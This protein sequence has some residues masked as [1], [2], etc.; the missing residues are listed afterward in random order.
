LY[1]PSTAGGYYG[2]NVYGSTPNGNEQATTI[3]ADI[4]PFELRDV[5]PNEG[6]NTGYVTLELTGSRFRPNMEVW[7]R[8]G[9]D[10]IHADTLIYESYYRSFARFNLANRDTGAYDVGVSSYCEGESVLNDA[11]RIVAG[12]PE[13]LVTNLVFPNAPRPNRMA[14]LTLEFGNLGNVDI[15]NAVL[16]ITSAGGCP[17]S[18]T[19]EGL[20]AHSTTLQIPL[21][22]EGQPDGL[23]R[24]GSSGTVNIYTYTSGSLIFMTTRIR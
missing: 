20:S 22:I 11:F 19:A 3:R 8:Q 18:L 5:D 24:P 9:G 6:G 13:H 12:E 16:E 17:I 14:V 23:L 10:T 7:M 1:I 2:V 4:L 21:T 15:R